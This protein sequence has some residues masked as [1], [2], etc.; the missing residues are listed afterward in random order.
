M[1]RNLSQLKYKGEE[2]KNIHAAREKVNNLDSRVR[3]QAKQPSGLKEDKYITYAYLE[4]TRCSKQYE[5]IR[6]LVQGSLIVLL[7]SLL[8]TAEAATESKKRRTILTSVPYLKTPRC[9][10]VWAFFFIE[11]SVL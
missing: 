6:L 9:R 5:G 2:L 7:L 1:D 3:F 8:W 4:T 10:H 11:F